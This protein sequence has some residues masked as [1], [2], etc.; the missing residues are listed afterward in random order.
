MSMPRTAAIVCNYNMPERTDALVEHIHKTVKLP[1]EVIVVDNGSDIVDPSKYTTVQVKY[2]LQTTK[3]FM[4]GMDYA[5][6]LDEF[7][8]YWL[9]ITSAE[10]LDDPR[11]SLEILMKVMR[12]DPKTYA[13]SPAFTFNWSA[14]DHWMSPREGKDSPRRVW[15]IDYIAALID[16]EKLKKIGGFRK[17]LTMMWGVQG[18]C[19]MLARKEGWHI[20]VHDGYTMHKESN[21]GYKMNRMN[22]TADERATLATKEKEAVLEEIYGKNFRYK[23]K[24]AYRENPDGEY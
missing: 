24:H 19:N 2:N 21:I 23:L 15:G 8:Y 11:D 17:E 7:D 18:E 3:G 20:Y 14:W 6:Y 22:M 13:V 5:D 16:K 1:C 10:F 4:I 12:N 9:F